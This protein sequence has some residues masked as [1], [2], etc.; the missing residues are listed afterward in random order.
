MSL[1]IDVNFVA[2]VQ[3]GESWENMPFE[4]NQFTNNSVLVSVF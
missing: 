2:E 4:F 3:C 1:N